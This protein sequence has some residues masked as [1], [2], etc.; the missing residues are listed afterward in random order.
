[1]SWLFLKYILVNSMNFK[2]NNLLSVQA[3]KESEMQRG[4]NKQQKKI[5][6]KQ[7]KKWTQTLWENSIGE[8][9]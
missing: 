1:M 9:I 8:G 2:L 5:K 3:E 4:E 7:N 6:T